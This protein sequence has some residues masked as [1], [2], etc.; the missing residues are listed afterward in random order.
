MMG[1]APGG[2]PPQ[3]TEE[4][5]PKFVRCSGEPLKARKVPERCELHRYHYPKPYRLVWHHL[6]PLGMG[7]PDNMGNMIGACDTGHYNIH[8]ALSALVFGKPMPKNTTRSE[9]F[10]A[11]RGYNKWLIAGKP[12]NP[13]AAYAMTH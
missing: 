3:V 13:H 2:K 1:E 12:G 5:L 7:G 6:Q 9:R 11:L 10:A 8:G 4:P